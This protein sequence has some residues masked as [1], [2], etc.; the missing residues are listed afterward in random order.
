MRDI[1]SVDHRRVIFID[2]RANVPSADFFGFTPGCYV[3]AGTNGERVTVA[4]FN[5]HLRGIATIVPPDP[6]ETDTSLTAPSERVLHK[7]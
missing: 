5:R 3:N 7:L 1:A 2:T 4:D 6:L